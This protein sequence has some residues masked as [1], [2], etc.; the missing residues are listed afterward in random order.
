MTLSAC[1][2][3]GAGEAILRTWAPVSLVTIG[4]RFN[5][6]AAR[7]GWGFDPHETI[8]IPD[9]DTWAVYVDHTN[10]AGWRDRDHARAKTPGV[11]RVLVL[12]DSITYGAI[13]GLE[14]L[15]TRALERVLRERGY[16]VEVISIGLGGW[17]TDQEL[18]ALRLEGLSYAPDVVV[19]EYT[20]NDPGDNLVSLETGLKPFRY[21]LGPGRS[22]V[23]RENP[24]FAAKH[25]EELKDLRW[26]RLRNRF[27][28]LKRWTLL[29]E[30]LDGTQRPSA[31]PAPGQG[32]QIDYVVTKW[33]LA[34]LSR[35][36][37]VD[38]QSELTRWVRERIGQPVSEADLRQRILASPAA[39]HV[40]EVLRT[41]ENH[42]FQA[43]WTR[44]EDL[45][46]FSAQSE[47]WPLLFLIFDEMLRLTRQAGAS[48]L[49]FS[50]HEQGHYDWDRYWFHIGEGPELRERFLAM[51]D[52]LREWAR[53]RQVDFLLPDRPIVRA[54]NDP[55]PNREGNQVMALTLARHLETRY[56]LPR[57][58]AG[59]SSLSARP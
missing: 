34:M 23:R 36:F 2:A 46:R 35:E 15:F 24:Y 51:N 10:A 30:R 6:N 40:D 29:K 28:I 48:F 26:R 53:S 13:V 5:A 50:T 41:F 49:L 17:G 38:K 18:E 21:E 37:G 39:P 4:H 52:P 32:R 44:F 12:G 47:S 20:S 27:E 22:L 58:D 11:F 3:L 56:A 55:H 42:W 16:A 19:L 31:Q 1:L 54:R 8:V 7:Y 14:D 33:G 9:P 43:A 59:A 25:R 45:P 57:R